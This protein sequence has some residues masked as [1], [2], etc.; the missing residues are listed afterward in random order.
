VS[1][2]PKTKAEFLAAIAEAKAAN[3][4]RLESL[5]K[6]REIAD[7]LIS[8][9]LTTPDVIAWI[10]QRNEQIREML[11]QSKAQEQALADL[12]FEHNLD[13]LFAE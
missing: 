11:E 3:E 5:R 10:E 9:P 13:A 4:A 2:P 6:F 12:F 7:S 1:T 8:N